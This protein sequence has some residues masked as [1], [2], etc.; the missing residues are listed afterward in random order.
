MM[1]NT[2]WLRYYTEL[3]LFLFCSFLFDFFDATEENSTRDIQSN[4]S[5]KEVKFFPFSHSR[6]K[7]GKLEGISLKDGISPDTPPLGTN[8]NGP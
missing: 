2:I 1:Q 8:R 7:Q 4:L 6:T 5:G 3:F